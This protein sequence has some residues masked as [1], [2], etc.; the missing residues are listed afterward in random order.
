MYEGVQN[1]Y[2]SDNFDMLN[3]FYSLKYLTLLIM[4]GTW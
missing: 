2:F 1:L 3:A 4:V